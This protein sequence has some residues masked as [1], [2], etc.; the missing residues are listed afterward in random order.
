MTDTDL[1]WR[2]SHDQEMDR[3]IRDHMSEARARLDAEA[4]AALS[5]LDR[6]M[7]AAPNRHARRV[8]QKAKAKILKNLRTLDRR[9]AAMER[10]ARD[11]FGVLPTEAMDGAV[12]Q[13]MKEI[14]G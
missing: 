3:M 10:K 5:K 2:V 8:I 12:D 4:A 6:D 14:F 9:E 1:E 11:Q 13:A 7:E